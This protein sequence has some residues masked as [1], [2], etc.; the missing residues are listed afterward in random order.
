MA[1]ALF[2]VAH[3]DK[4]INILWLLLVKSEMRAPADDLQLMGSRWTSV[5]FGKS[6]F[7]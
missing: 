5:I 7:T 2:N 1:D 6:L 3:E 4:R